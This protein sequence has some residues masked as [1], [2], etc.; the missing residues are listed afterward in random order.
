MMKMLLTNIDQKLK[1]TTKNNSIS[2]HYLTFFSRN[3]LILI[4]VLAGTLVY[5]QTIWIANS[6]PGATTG[7][8]VK[9]GANAIND[10]LSDVTLLSGDIIQ[11]V[12][13]SVAYNDVH[14]TLNGLSFYGI[15]T[16]P[17]KEGNKVS[18]LN[19]LFLSEA[20]D[21]T[22]I[23]GMNINYLYFSDAANQTIN[24]ALIENCYLGIAEGYYA[25]V[26][27]KN[28]TLRNNIIGKSPI[29]GERIH[30]YASSNVVINNNI[31]ITGNSPSY[32]GI[33]AAN[34]TIISNNLFL[35]AAT[36]NYN[37]FGT[38][39]LCT[40]KNN[41]FYGLD[42]EGTNGAAVSSCSFLNNISYG[43]TI[44]DIA[45]LIA[46]NGNSGSANQSN[47]D[48]QMV[49]VPYATDWIFTYDPHLKGTS[50]ALAAGTDLTDMGITGGTVPF[51]FAGTYLPLIQQVTPSQVI[52]SGSTMPLTIKAK[53]N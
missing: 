39:N 40:V 38:L 35:G 16:N 29:T 49:N 32:D 33:S 2:C 11:V 52:N 28:L 36:A 31:I 45:A 43:G 23:S 12:P 24:G 50:T 27:V 42:M 14:V 8:H 3:V 47:T 20:A 5:G 1:N 37:A 25:S 18:Y 10:I 13:S 19:T 17:Q 53:G 34:G 30:T 46:A 22:V 48:P 7:N 9:T 44:T 51:N 41:I 6:N 4:M 15:G 26:T 21:N